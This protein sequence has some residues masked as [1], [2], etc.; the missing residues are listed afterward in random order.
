MLLLKDN[1]AAKL[2]VG[3]IDEITKDSHAILAR[4]GLYRSSSDSS[5][6][7]FDKET[8]GSLHG[9][10]A[11]FFLLTNEASH[12]NIACLEALETF[13]KPADEAAITTGI[14]H[15]LARQELSVDDIDLLITGNNGDKKNDAIFHQVRQDIFPAT[16]AIKYKH[17]SGDYPTANAFAC[18]LATEIIRQKKIPVWYAGTPVTK[19]APRSILIYNHQQMTHHS[20]ILLTAC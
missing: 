11:A 17:L 18:W 7:L 10:G 15:F 12:K 3:G 1:P 5:L 4:F 14:R 16:T 20:L 6:R 9:E 8:K 19:P 2:L 13:Y